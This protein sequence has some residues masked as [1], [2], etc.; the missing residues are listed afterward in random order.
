MRRLVFIGVLAIAALFAGSLVLLDRLS[1]DQP[2]ERVGTPA[3][4]NEASPRAAPEPALPPV[5]PP[6]QPLAPLPAEVARQLESPPTEPAP[7]LPPD[8]LPPSGAPPAPAYV[9]DV[10]PELQTMVTSRCG[11]LVLRLGDQLRAEGAGPEGHAV[12]L[13]DVEPQEDQ[14]KIWGSTLQSPG[15]TRPA[16]VACAQHALRGHRFE[17]SHLLPGQ[18]VKVQVVV[19]VR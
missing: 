16:L 3:T 15:S 18:R 4:R 11:E 14:A 1:P 19:G 2:P 9:R 13:L 12:L 6:P 8:P 7:V 5:A 10:L 17:V